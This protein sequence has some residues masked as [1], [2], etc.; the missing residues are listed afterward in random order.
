MGILLE[1]VGE[2]RMLGSM[3]FKCMFLACICAGKP[4]PKGFMLI[5]SQSGADSVLLHRGL[6]VKITNV[7]SH[8]FCTVSADD[9]IP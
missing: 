3:M 2:A 7:Q 5:T 1:L 9:A 8:K 4:R 6:K